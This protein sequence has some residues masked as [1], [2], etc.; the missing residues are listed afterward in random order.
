MVEI[1]SLSDE[2][3][4][5]D[6]RIVTVVSANQIA[7]REKI[8]RNAEQP[9]LYCCGYATSEHIYAEYEY[10]NYRK[11][12]W[13]SRIFWVVIFMAALVIIGLGIGL[14]VT[15]TK[16]STTTTTPGTTSKTTTTTT[17]TT[18]TSTTATSTT[19]TST[20]PESSWSEWSSCQPAYNCLDTVS[21]A[22]SCP[23]RIRSGKLWKDGQFIDVKQ[24]SPDE[25]N[26]QPCTFRLTGWTGGECTG[27]GDCPCH[28]T[29]YRFCQQL[30]YGT[31]TISHR[32]FG[33]MFSDGS[34]MK[35]YQPGMTPSL[36][37]CDPPGMD[38]KKDMWSSQC[39]DACR[40]G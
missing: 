2:D 18:P 10:F 39:G 9:S 36:Y 34:V 5:G 40:L 22:Q 1:T 24:E 28:W 17:T 14:G 23:V 25:C 37:A 16:S 21:S 29:E 4:I 20:T 3:A 32:K 35:T 27:G 6:R 38:T 13:K 30:S 19:T 7:E 11:T 12:F 26:C 15:S 31:Y 8:N 33:I